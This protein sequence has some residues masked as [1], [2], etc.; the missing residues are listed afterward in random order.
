MNGVQAMPCLERVAVERE[1]QRRDRLADPRAAALP[2]EDGAAVLG[3][4]ATEGVEGEHPHHVAD[5]RRRHDHLVAARLQRDLGRGPVEPAPDLLL[6]ALE[7][8]R[9]GGLAD[10]GRA[11]PVGRPPDQAHRARRLR[12][13]EPH[14]GGAAE[15]QRDDVLL[16]EAR[17]HGV[18][19]TGPLE[20][21]RQGRQHDL[22]GAG[23]PS[24][25]DRARSHACPPAGSRPAPPGERHRPPAEPPGRRPGRRRPSRPR[26]R[27]RPRRS[28][29][30]SRTTLP[31]SAMTLTERPR[32]SPLVVVVFSA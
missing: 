16:G 15:V 3:V 12:V 32:C 25:R 29:G 24:S 9:N 6:H 27:C 20:C 8:G 10:P 17:Q 1:R 23:S 31:L 13:G 14:A 5:G 4:L 21:A 11:A 30:R 7:R 28:A 18:A 2:G 26:R 19:G 22:E